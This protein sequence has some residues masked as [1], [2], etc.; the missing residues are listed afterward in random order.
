MTDDR[1]PALF[2]ELTAQAFAN[3]AYAMRRELALDT[4]CMQHLES[5]SRSAKSYAAHLTR[6]CCGLAHGGDP[7]V[8]EAIQKWLNGA[9]KLEKTP[10]L[11]Q[12]GSLTV[13]DVRKARTAEEH[14]RLVHDWATNVWEAYRSQ[15]DIARAWITAALNAQ[16][17]TPPKRN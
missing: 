7:K 8:Y 11:A 16:Q 14:A 9:A 4:Y 6:L 12:L 15:H 5:Y 17:G 13:A 1:C 2:D 10:V 3:P